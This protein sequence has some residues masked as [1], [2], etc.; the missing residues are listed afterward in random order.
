MLSRIAGVRPLMMAPTKARLYHHRA[1]HTAASASEP[2]GH[3]RVLI[4]GS[5]GQLGTELTTLLRSKYG[6]DNVIASDIR[7]PSGLMATEGP[8]V[9]ADVLNYEQLESLVVDYR[10][11]QVVHFSALLS[12]VG[13]L[14]VE[15]ALAVN[16]QGFQNVLELSKNHKLMLFS[17]STIGAFGTSTPK[18]DAGTPDLTIMRPTTVYGISKVHMELLGEYYHKRFGVDFRSLRYPGI[19]SADAEPGGGTTDYAVDIFHHAINKPSEPFK[20]FLEANQA[21]PMMYLS[22]CLKATVDMMEAPASTL[23]SG[24]TYNVNAMSFDV[25]ELAASIKKHVP[26]LEVECE[27]DFRQQIAESWPKKLDDTNARADWGW[28]HAYDLD[29]MVSE[30]LTLIKQ[31]SK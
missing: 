16:I 5:L 9:Y 29:T 30:M 20:C 6:A 14:N 13:E 12:A 7:K 8:F 23:T 18:P 27:P 19:I 4:T 21:L 17:P 15:K 31:Q 11:D 1:K 3:P 2:N 10:V 28:N 24:R 25:M 26:T 22:D